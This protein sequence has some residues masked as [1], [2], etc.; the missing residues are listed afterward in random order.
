MSADLA[1][2]T[3]P[4]SDSELRALLLEYRQEN[5]N[6]IQPPEIQ[7]QIVHDLMYGD[8]EGLLRVVEPYIQLSSTSRI[9]DIGSGVGSFVAA[10][11]RRGL[12]AF[13]VEPDK[14]AQGSKL[15]SIQIARRRIA[16]T[17]FVSGIGE[18]LPFPNAFFDLVTLNQVIEHVSDQEKVIREASRVVSERGVVYIA[19][20]NYLRFYEPHYKLFWLP[21]MPKSLG[22]LY[23]RLRGRNPVMLEQLTYTT[24]RR[25]R[26]LLDA[27]GSGYTVIDLHREQLLR[28][29]ASGSFSARSTR[30][31]ANL[32]GLPVVGTAVLWCLLRYASITEG[33][34]AMLL[35][36]KTG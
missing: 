5:W 25:L 33:G 16:S 31:V 34:C 18:Q 26:K 3:S 19:C 1:P 21:L 30:L 14:I 7:E 28:K 4:V 11:K 6:G 12:Q 8:A 9:L 35:I 36:R 32:A 27:A 24:N 22:R 20:P 13:G 2:E 10:C 23:L 17:V 15:T 29:R